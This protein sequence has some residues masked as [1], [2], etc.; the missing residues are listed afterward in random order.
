MITNTKIIYIEQPALEPQVGVLAGW[1]AVQSTLLSSTS[2]LREGRNLLIV[3]ICIS[4]ESCCCSC[5]SV[6]HDAAAGLL[7][8]QCCACLSIFRCWDLWSKHQAAEPEP[9]ALSCFLPGKLVGDFIFGFQ[10]IRSSL[11]LFFFSGED[12]FK[13]L[14]SRSNWSK[15][16]VIVYE[17]LNQIPYCSHRKGLFFCESR[18]IVCVISLVPMLASLDALGLL[19][20]HV[21]LLRG[22]LDNACLLWERAQKVEDH[23]GSTVTFSG[24]RVLDTVLAAVTPCQPAR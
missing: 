10:G 20:L 21:S 12:H 18:A 3:I 1:A 17:I 16:G 7:R 5:C 2:L 4:L 13:I 14:Q 24:R 22:K 6:L 9:W 19:F 8:Q 11:I 15:G 23:A